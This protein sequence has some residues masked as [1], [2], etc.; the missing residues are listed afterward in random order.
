MKTV[1]PLRV[2]RVDPDQ[3]VVPRLVEGDPRPGAGLRRRVY[4]GCRRGV[5]RLPGASA[6]VRAEDVPLVGL[7]TGRTS[8]GRRRRR[9]HQGHR[10]RALHGRRTRTDAL[11]HSV[12][13]APWSV[14][15]ARYPD[16]SVERPAVLGAREPA[17]ARAHDAPRRRAEEQLVVD[18]R[19]RVVRRRVLDAGV[20][21][22]AV[23]RAEEAAVGSDEHDVVRAARID[24]DVLDR[25]R[26][27]E[28][29]RA[30]P[31][32]AAVRRL[33]HQAADPCSRRERRKRVAE[34]EVERVR[35][36][37]EGDRPGRERCRAGPSAT[38]RSDAAA[39][40]SSSSRA[41]PPRGGRTRRSESRGSTRI[42]APARSRSR[43]CSSGRCTRRH[44]CGSPASVR[45]I[46]TPGCRTAPPRPA[47]APDR[48]HR[49]AGSLLRLVP[50]GPGR[51]L[52]EAGTRRD[53]ASEY[54]T[55]VVAVRR[56]RRGG[57]GRSAPV[58]PGNDAARPMPRGRPVA[59]AHASRA[60]AN[61]RAPR[62]A[63]TRDCRGTG[64][65]GTLLALGRAC[66]LA[67][68]GGRD[69]GSRADS[70][71]P[72]SERPRLKPEAS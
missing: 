37:T 19:A 57:R 2:C 60:S 71:N 33:E 21:R 51:G 8:P 43:R 41:R 25:I 12:Q 27:A 7:S 50:R 18:R 62:W 16:A 49:D 39:R 54:S 48:P 6:V 67:T 59:V 29:N 46:A 26:S 9:C 63:R 69:M 24:G 23:G 68:L 42:C 31:R 17:H 10:R 65:H 52:V 36:R 55:V 58:W 53:Q 66:P 56:C 11:S 45:A 40:S 3:L 38:S 64:L 20:G 70:R 28:R 5:Q 22:A 34:T 47:L 13:V 32:C 14:E 1:F 4:R 72:S 44:G 35:R 61:V 15:H 30:R